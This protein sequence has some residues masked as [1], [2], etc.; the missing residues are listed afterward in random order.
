MI[1]LVLEISRDNFAVDAEG[2][3]R[4]DRGKAAFRGDQFDDLREIILDVRGDQELP[5]WDQN[6]RTSGNKFWR[7][8]SPLAM[9][10]F[11]PH[12]SGK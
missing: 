1:A 7:E 11:P 3:R 4:H 10:L 9:A 12:G 6:G 8:Q 5:T 2:A